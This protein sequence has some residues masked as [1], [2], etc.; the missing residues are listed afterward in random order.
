MKFL[1]I[2]LARRVIIYKLWK[3]IYH[4]QS[5]ID[6]VH[7][8]RCSMARPLSSRHTG[9]LIQDSSL[10]RNPNIGP[11]SF[12]PRTPTRLSTR[13]NT[14]DPNSSLTPTPSIGLKLRHRANTRLNHPDHFRRTCPRTFRKSL[15]RNG[16][17]KVR[18][19]ISLILI[20]G[21]CKMKENK[22]NYLGE[23]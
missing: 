11:H 5:F 10:G 7:D 13:L 17:I 21:L 20:Y 3:L 6:R 8:Y 16:N 1:F 19:H 4:I 12:L 2:K 14:T 23:S 9:A 15:N 22:F 18:L